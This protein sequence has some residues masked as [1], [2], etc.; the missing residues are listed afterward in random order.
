MEH[1]SSSTIRPYLIARGRLQPEQQTVP[2]EALVERLPV[3]APVGV[4]SESVALLG[5]LGDPT[6]TGVPTYLSLAELSAHLKLPVVVVRLLV[7]DLVTAGQVRVHGL[8]EP[9]ARGDKDATLRLLE[10]VLHGISTY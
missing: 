10:S 9:G 5:L 1:T 2:L 7:A 4:T 8:G 6:G 3:A